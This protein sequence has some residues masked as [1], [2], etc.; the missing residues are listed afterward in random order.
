MLPS[1]ACRPVRYQCLPE[2]GCPPL[3]SQILYDSSYFFGKNVCFFM[4]FIDSSV[5]LLSV[6]TVVTFSTLFSKLDGTYS[7]A[8]IIANASTWLFVHLLSIL[9]IGSTF[10]FPCLIMAIPASTSYSDLLQSAYI[11]MRV[12]SPCVLSSSMIMAPSAG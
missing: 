3:A 5:V 6:Y 9:F 4:L 10:V 2:S 7:S 11:F 12:R 8:L 1:L